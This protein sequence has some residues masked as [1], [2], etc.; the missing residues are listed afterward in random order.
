MPTALAKRLALVLALAPILLAS[1]ARAEPYSAGFGVFVGIAFGRHD[2]VEWGFEA[3]ELT[4]FHRPLCTDRR[5]S[6]VGPLVQFA[7]IGIRVPRIT[8]AMQAGQEIHDNDS[9][10]TGE[11][12]ATYR[13]GSES[14][15][16]LHLGLTPEYAPF[17]ASL[18]A[19]MFLDD[20]SGVVGLRLPPTFGYAQGCSEFP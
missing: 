5:R 20:Y 17:N 18:R 10:V 16:G 2:G 9:S 14:G 12:G 19:Q 4:H 13:W 8:I 6:G 11:L 15:Y 1:P 7:M 3:F